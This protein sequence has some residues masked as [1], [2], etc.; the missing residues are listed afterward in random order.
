MGFSQTAKPEAVVRPGT[1]EEI[2]EIIT[3]AIDSGTAIIPVGGGTQIRQV[4]TDS[5][6]GIGLCMGRVNQIHE[7]EVGNFSITAEAGT[8]HST[9]KEMVNAENLQLPIAADF[10]ASTIGGEVAT[11]FSSVKRYK[12]GT[13]GNYVLGLTFIS[14][15][16]KFVKTGGKTVKNASGYDF[17]KLLSG[18]WGTMGILN[19]VTFKLNPLPE[20]EIKLVR[21]FAGTDDAIEEGVQIL[22]RKPNVSGCNI[23]NKPGSEETS[24]TM[25][26]S[27]EGSREFIDSQ[28]K[29]L[30]LSSSWNVMEEESVF[31]SAEASHLNMRREMKRRYFNTVIVD[32]RKLLASQKGLHFLMQQGCLLDFDLSA[33]VL[34]FSIP[35]DT[36]APFGLFW[37]QWNFFTEELK[38][39]VI[40]FSS[41]ESAHPLLD[42]LL[43]IIDPH[44]IMF[45]N[46]IFSRRYHLG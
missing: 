44:K 35:K 38:G 23:F 5:Q 39:K 8:L 18:S 11:N 27:L 19:S 16:G 13:V 1:L 41:G 2:K 46:N 14:P 3:F 26:I 25:S 37:N 22:S 12:F 20:T 7:F 29:Y 28:I 45:R 42:R 15:T 43:P 4:L 34:E 17:T 30:S 9:V 32:K 24:V 31:K 36:S 33:G 40:H 21:D 10:N 6:A